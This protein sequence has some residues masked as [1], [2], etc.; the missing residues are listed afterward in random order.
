MEIDHLKV[1]HFTE[2]PEELHQDIIL[3]YFELTGREGGIFGIENIPKIVEAGFVA[4]CING[5]CEVM[6]DHVVYNFKAGQMCVGLTATVVQTL[7]KSADLE[8]VLLAANIEFLRNINI[9]SVSDIFITIRNNPCVSLSKEEMIALPSY[10]RYIQSVYNRKE[11]S[12]RIEMTK[13][14]LLVICYEIAAIYQKNSISHK[15]MYSYKDNVFR[16]FV[17]LLAN[18]HKE[19]RRVSYYAQELCVTSKYLSSVI[20][21]VSNK[22]AAEWIDDFVLRNVKIFLST[23]TLTIQQISDEFNFPNPSFFTQY[24]KRATGKTPKAFRNESKK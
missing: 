22:S 14:L 5:E 4:I 7:W 9:P 10:F 11:H 23:T 13:H 18:K 1:E 21:D 15:Q 8:C 6:I 16:N 12:Y 19:E 2:N 24:F 20:K 17:R 3:K